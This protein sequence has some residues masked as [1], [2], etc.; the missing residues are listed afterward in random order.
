MCRIRAQQRNRVLCISITSDVIISCIAQTSH[1][2][3][4]SITRL[5]AR[6]QIECDAMQWHAMS[7]KCKTNDIHNAMVCHTTISHHTSQCTVLPNGWYQAA[8]FCHMQQYLFY[9][10]WSVWQNDA[11]CLGWHYLS[12]AT[13]LFYQCFVVSRITVSCYI[14]RNDWITPALDT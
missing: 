13:C 7:Y 9:V 11:G 10:P 4:D 14:I 8:T 1:P 12:H 2:V 6:T 3:L 5:M